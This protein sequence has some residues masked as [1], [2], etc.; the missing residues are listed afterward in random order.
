MQ[1]QR[2]AL[3]QA[4]IYDRVAYTGTEELPATSGN[5]A[6]H[7]SDNVSFR[8]D[9][10]VLLGST[11]YDLQSNSSNCKRISMTPDGRIA[12]T[13]TQGNDDTD[14]YPDRGT[15][16]NTR[17]D[18]QWGDLP[19]ERLESERTG[20]PNHVYTASGGEFTVAHTSNNELLTLRRSGPME[21]WI[22][23][24]IPTMV[25]GGLLWPRAAVGGADGETIH[26]IAISAPVANGGELYQDVDGHLLYFR[27]LDGGA[28]WDQ[29]DIAIEGLGS[30]FT[31]GSGADAYYIDARDDNVA[32]GVF[33]DWDDVL[34]FKSA[35]NGDTW[36]K[37]IINDFPLVKY[38]INSG[39][40]IADIPADPFAP[41][42]LA[43]FTSDNYGTVLIDHD[44]MAHAFFG[45][46]YVQD[47]DLTDM[48]SS[49]FPAT[50]G[51]DY[52]NETFGEDSTRTIVST[53]DVNMND[54]LDVA[55]IGNI[56]RYFASLTSMPS[57][58]ID[59]D[60]NIYLTY[61]GVR[62]DLLDIEDDQHYRHIYVTVSSDGAETWTEPFDINIPE[63]ATEA[64][65]VDFIEGV[66]PTMVRDVDSKVRL[67]YQLD[68]RPGLSVRGDED[69]A[70]GNFIPYVQIDVAEFGLVDTEELVEPE[71]FRLTLAPNLTRSTSNLSFDLPQRGPI[72]I[73]LV[74]MHG[75]VVRN[76]VSGQRA[77]GF[78]Q[79]TID[80]SH[81]A[82]GTYFV[83]LQT[84]GKYSAVRLIKQ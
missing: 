66:F 77:A 42:T 61:S 43:I 25:P 49:F 38:E 80:L 32:F 71:A 17:I 60:G 16:Y 78:H 18:F 52:W 68:Y 62:E 13:W 39:Y 48:G 50:D 41:D 1:K 47:T 54:T 27:S 56:A 46:M 44:G 19:D 51:I 30:D 67:I 81:E 73:D 40:T 12:G 5:E 7:F 21:D 45:R 34:L 24:A 35:D 64:D 10:E 58:G 33:N 65:L 74:N 69:D 59:A 70:A 6:Y 63:I 79:E 53:V 36:T 14:G 84:S 2:A 75:Q 82:R 4:R 22:E 37:H 31:L 8:V 9:Q 83:M 26:V 55:T 29:T 11:L 72:R 76:L 15:G 28:S 57:A 20:W 23:A 3:K